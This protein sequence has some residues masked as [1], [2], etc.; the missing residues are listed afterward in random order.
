ME[1]DALKKMEDKLAQLS[2]I[3]PHLRPLYYIDESHFPVLKPRY[4][5]SLSEFIKL[6]LFLEECA[7]AQIITIAIFFG[8]IIW[9]VR[10]KGKYSE[11]CRKYGYSET[12][13]LI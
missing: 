7:E 2:Q 9:H 6:F 8:E 13:F 11:T 10:E 5:K 1:L 3:L 12:D 4:R